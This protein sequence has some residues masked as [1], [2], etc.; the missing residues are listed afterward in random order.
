MQY[1]ARAELSN[2]EFLTLQPNTLET[3][4][5]DPECHLQGVSGD[6]GLLENI[7]Y[8]SRRVISA[9]YVVMDLFTEEE[10][11]RFFRASLSYLSFKSHL[12]HKALLNLPL[13]DHNVSAFMEL[14]G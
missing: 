14:F 2:P 11:G 13:D 6:G 3:P 10:L 4:L 1:Q 9:S 7:K 5:S 12:L 8:A